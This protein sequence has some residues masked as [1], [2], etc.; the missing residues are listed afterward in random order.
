MN[1]VRY[2]LLLSWL[3]KSQAKEN[4]IFAE[5]KKELLL[6]NVSKFHRTES[7]SRVLPLA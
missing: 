7:N 5:I 4:R 6:C 3:N 1:T 2:T